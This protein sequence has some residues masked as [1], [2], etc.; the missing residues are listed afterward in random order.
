MKKGKVFWGIQILLVA[1]FIL[2]GCGKNN[3][4]SS[5]SEKAESSDKVKTV[6]VAVQE[7]SK[8][9]SY[10]DDKGNITGYEAEVIKKIDKLIPEYK[11]DLEAVSGSAEEVGIDAGKY[12]LIAQGFFKTDEREEKYL[13]PDENTGV[14]LL[15]IFTLK[16]NDSINT[17]DDLVGVK[18]APIPPNGG[19]FK[20]LTK[21]NE[22]HPDKKIDFTTAENVPIANKFQSLKDGEYDAFIWPINGIDFDAITQNF[23]DIF[24]QSEPIEISP[25]YFLI[26]KNQK[27]LSEKVNVAIKKLKDDGELVKLSKKFFGFNVFDELKE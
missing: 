9:V 2:V 23:G 8:P 3:S 12:A 27:D 1:A 10:I 17:L 20:L 11:F 7:G 26:N 22:E 5:S 16:K 24:R 6:S 13:L 19:Q 4:T 15:K 14:T 25:T 21:Y 18:L